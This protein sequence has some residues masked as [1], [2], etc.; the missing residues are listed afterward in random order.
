MIHGTASWEHIGRK[1]LARDLGQSGLQGPLLEYRLYQYTAI[2]SIV[3]QK[4]PIQVFRISIFGRARFDRFRTIFPE[5]RLVF[6]KCNKPPFFP[7]KALQIG[8]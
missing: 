1:P 4:L 6:K 2:A 3:G 7:W 8:F 5:Y